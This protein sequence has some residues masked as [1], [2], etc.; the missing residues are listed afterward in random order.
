MSFIPRKQRA[1][2]Q[3]CSVCGKARSR[4]DLRDIKG[5][6]FYNELR[7]CCLC[8]K[9]LPGPIDGPDWPAYLRLNP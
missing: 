5:V 2:N 6:H 7:F 4:E 3:A 8:W 9:V 1:R